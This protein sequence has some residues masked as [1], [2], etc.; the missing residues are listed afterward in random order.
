M[1]L[2][3]RTLLAYLDNILEPADARQLGTRIE[4]SEFA[5]G[6]VH[7]I[8]GVT[9]KL[10]LGAPKLSGRGMGLD[11]NT[12]AE[13]LDNT[14]PQDRVPDFEKVC[15]ESD[16]HLAEVASC[17]QILTLVLG[18]PADVDPVLHERIKGLQS[19]MDSGEATEQ[20]KRE[21]V[22][23]DASSAAVEAP[24]IAQGQPPRNGEAAPTNHPESPLVTPSSKRTPAPR[25]SIR[26]L[27]V[28]ATL[29]VAFL[30]GLASLL[31]MGP[32]N[33]DHPILGG[34]L[35]QAS[36]AEIAK[37]EASQ[38]S[39][40][41]PPPPTAKLKQ[42][43]TANGGD[44]G[45]TGTETELADG[46][47]PRDGSEETTEGSA[48]G[49]DSPADRTE[50]L[51]TG[52]DP[53]RSSAP[54]NGPVFPTPPTESKENP[55][56]GSR[57]TGLEENSE[58]TRPKADA[59]LDAV[60]DG[61]ASEDTEGTEEDTEGTEEDT[62]ETEEDT[63]ETEG[64]E[65]S[66]TGKEG[67][68]EPE[69][70]ARCSSPDQILACLDAETDTWRRL[71]TD[72]PVPLERELVTLPIYRPRITF[73]SGME[74]TLVGPTACSV[75][76]ADPEGIPAMVVEYGRFVVNTGD[77][78]EATLKLQFGERTGEITLLPPESSLAVDVK[79]YHQPG[80]NPTEKAAHR[81][82]QLQ[83][84]SGSME[85][86]D[87]TTP[88]PVVLEAGQLASII[89]LQPPRITTE[90][91]PLEWL[92]TSS[93]RLI[94]RDA[95]RRLES[96][97]P[98]DQPLRESLREQATS[99]LVEVRSLSTRGLCAL[100]T[101][102]SFLVDALNSKEYHTFWPDLISALQISLAKSPE[103]AAELEALLERLRGEQGRQLF[104]YLWGF[105][106]EQLAE[107]EAGALVESLA[108][109]SMDVRV[110]AF[111]TLYRIVGKTN[112]YDPAL[113]PERQK[114]AI[115]NWK[116]DL[117]Q[118][119]ITYQTPPFDPSE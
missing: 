110:L 6:L 112:S 44:A 94:D 69:P 28:V 29:V 56:A 33:S 97:L 117:K 93:T 87:S 30:L 9:R 109:P 68:A 35:P 31:L 48:A 92:D 76:S 64:T 8:R 102:D 98:L 42:G 53:D 52:T 84:V 104:R 39:P 83:T 43:P 25:S 10:R 20:G 115:L 116:R 108:S 13:Y 41:P 22:S 51:G 118:D 15:L 80:T 45:E 95:S 82:I 81:L 103:T 99:R 7:R 86:R 21:G 101:Y 90:D 18:E 57:A 71:T 19:R 50:A 4:E 119:E 36:D 16:V 106:P 91:S 105:T 46:E 85:W 38:T 61:D 11:A 73:K 88:E 23:N 54:D 55:A 3:L 60:L 66:D 113:P 2:T 47:S 37:S 79:R 17:H 14:L 26:L 32:L 34:L 49:G 75:H 78:S 63:E 77:A 12:V 59:A 100:G 114:R 111:E 62:E 27:P 5:S 1:R 72:D 40:G 58:A 70:F 107:G 67:A 65:A 74:V 24:P 89:N 96:L